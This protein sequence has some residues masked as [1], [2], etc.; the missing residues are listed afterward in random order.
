MSIENIS[1]ILA[2]QSKLKRYQKPLEASRVCQTARGCIDPRWNIIS[3]KNGLLTVGVT[4]SAEAANL[5]MKSIEII[6]CINK[7]L[8]QEMVKR[9]RYRVIG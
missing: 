2:G 9:L 3:F 5:Q 7:K 6:E 4:S 1:K 8:G